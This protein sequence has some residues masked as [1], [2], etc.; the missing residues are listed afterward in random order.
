MWFDILFLAVLALFALV[1]LFQGIINQIF[2]LLGLVGIWVYVR[3]LA[4]QAAVLI[5]VQTGFTEMNAY[6]T[7]LVAGSSLI[8]FVFLVVGLVVT[9]L[10]ASKDEGVKRTNS[11]LGGLLGLVKGVLVAGFV[12]CVLDILPARTFQ[13]MPEVGAN[14]AQS[15]AVKA[16]GRFNPL[17]DF[18]F[19]LNFAAYADVLKDEK[20]QAALQNQPAMIELA[21]RNEV[22]EVVNDV[23]VQQ[24]IRERK[25]LKLLALPRVRKLLA[26]PE[27]RSLLN[28]IDPEAAVKTAGSTQ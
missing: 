5:A 18:R 2:R 21:N 8:Y 28:Q 27:I 25:L 10:V 1:G 3:F 15:L 11:F 19:V 20:A 12:F 22:R 16:V 9:R 23:E 17:R 24:L 6:I 26:D 14:L 4:Q 7:A 13:D